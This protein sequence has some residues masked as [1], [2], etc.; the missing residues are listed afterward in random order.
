MKKFLQKIGRKLFGFESENQSLMW[1]TVVGGPDLN[2]ERK[3]GFLDANIRAIGN[4][5]CNGR[6][7]LKDNDGQEIVYTKK[8]DNPLLDLLYQPSRFLTQNQFRQIITAHYLIY[9]NIFI[10]KNGRDRQGRPTELIPIP[11]PSEEI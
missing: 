3:N 7:S 9:G 4:A 8:G 11:A 6:L 5:L 2:R 10:L 1:T